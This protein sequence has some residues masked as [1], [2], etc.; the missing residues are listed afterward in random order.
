MKRAVLFDMDGTLVDSS[1]MHHM[2]W[3]EICKPLNLNISDEMFNHTLGFRNEDIIRLYFPNNPN[4]KEIEE[5]A[6]RKEIIFRRLVTEDFRPIPG[7][8]ELIAAL[9]DAGWGL[10]LCTS[11]GPVNVRTIMD[12]MPEGGRIGVRVNE[13]MITRGKPDPEIFLQAAETLGVD[14]QMC[15]VIEDGKAGLAGARA[16]GMLAVGIT[17]T[18]SKEVMAPL[19]DMVIDR[20]SEL[21]PK[22]LE[23]MLDDRRRK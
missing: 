5:Y 23:K 11:A 8:S 6:E 2:A 4:E 18:F 15:V 16:A 7:A 1:P 13:T 17:T 14:P 21:S 19:A 10:G 22:L 3:R 20:Y 12:N 9:D